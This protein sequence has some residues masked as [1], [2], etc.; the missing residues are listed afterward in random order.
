MGSLRGQASLLQFRVVRNY[1]GRHKSVGARLARE[2]ARKH[3][4]DQ[5]LRTRKLRHNA[6]TIS[7]LTSAQLQAC[8]FCK[9]S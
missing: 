7:T 8:W 1:H 9:P 6:A 5:P 2:E 4:E 3:A